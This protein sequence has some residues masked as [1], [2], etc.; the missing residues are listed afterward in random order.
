MK[1]DGCVDLLTQGGCKVSGK[2]KLN[3]DYHFLL[4]PGGGGCFYLPK[5]PS[6][7]HPQGRR[8]CQESCRPQ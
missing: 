2:A 6:F 5:D 4:G 3:R 8:K 1:N 7:L